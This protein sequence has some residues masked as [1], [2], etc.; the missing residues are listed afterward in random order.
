MYQYSNLGKSTLMRALAAR[1]VGDVPPNVTVHYV[2]QEVVLTEESKEMTPC[3]HVVAAD[4]ERR[5]LMAESYKLEALAETGNLGSEDQR[6]Q[7]EVLEQLELIEASSAERRADDLLKALGF[8]DELRARKLKDL[9]GG[10]RVRTMLAAAIFARPDLLLLDEPTNHLSISAVLW[11]AREL[12]ENEVWKDRTVVI[13]S[14]DRYFIDSVCS[15]VLHIS[16]VARR[17]TQTH[18]NYTTWATR[19]AEQQIAYA[20]QV[21]LRTAEVE[22]LR[23]YADHGFKYGGSQSQLNKMAMKMKQAEKIETAADIMNEE[24]AALQED[25]EYPVNLLSGGELPGFLINLKDVAFNYP[26]QPLLFDNVDMGI[27]S[28]SKMVFLGENGM[29]NLD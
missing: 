27:T 25:V 5:E 26:N 15:D 4:I 20:K 22:K 21:A 7:V 28:Q 3:E 17:L 12:S 19:R 1:R 8:S 9:S 2:T 18:G 23:E 11:L 6:R 24:L 10:W 29:K 13:V 16:G 14:H